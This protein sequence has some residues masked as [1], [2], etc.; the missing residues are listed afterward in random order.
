MADISV[1]RKPGLVERTGFRLSWGAI[2]AGLFVA[3]GLHLVLALLGIAIGFTAW[4]PARPGGVDPGDVATGVGIWAAI[5]ALIALFVGGTTTGRLAGVLTQRD[6]ALHGVVLWALSTIVVLWLVVS[7]LGFILGGAFGILGRTAAATVE[8]VG[9]AATQA[10]GPALTGVVRG[11]ERETLVQE[12]AA[13]TGL[14]RAEAEQVVA[15]AEMQ[16]QQVRGRVGTQIDT[17][18]ARAPQI[19]QDVSDTAASAAWWSL[20][21]LALSLAAATAGTTLTSRE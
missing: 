19:A 9:G 12:L 16:T 14:S 1:D 8:T 7:G 4:D 17:L 5:S 15:D 13:R 21:A 18:Q 6:G 2:F 11:E 20:L 3:V 10:A